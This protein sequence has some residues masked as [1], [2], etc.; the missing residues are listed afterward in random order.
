MEIPGFSA[1]RAEP[2]RRTHTVE[3]TGSNPVAPTRLKANRQRKISVPSGGRECGLKTPNV[4]VVF[5]K[6]FRRMSDLTRIPK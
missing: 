3:V 2:S 5:R 6:G 1:P 4:A